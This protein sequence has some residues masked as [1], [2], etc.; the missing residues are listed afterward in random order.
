MLFEKHPYLRKHGFEG[1]IM[2][3]GTFRCILH[4]YLAEEEAVRISPLEGND[5]LTEPL[6]TCGL[7]A[8]STTHIKP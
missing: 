7:G 3:T 4:S 2:L 6:G 8:F 5:S 1:E